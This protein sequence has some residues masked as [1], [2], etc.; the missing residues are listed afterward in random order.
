M[1]LFFLMDSNFMPAKF[2]ILPKLMWSHRSSIKIRRKKIIKTF[3][4]FNFIISRYCNLAK[5]IKFLYIFTLHV[6]GAKLLFIKK[7]FVYLYGCK[8]TS[9][10]FNTNQYKFLT[11][12][13]TNFI[14]LLRSIELTNFF[15][16]L[17]LHSGT[18]NNPN[19]ESH[20]M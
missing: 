18:Q 9:F 20:G 13:K 7:I 16:P 1:I 4:K 15:V 14:L 3:K 12:R 2:E 11:R 19:R 5:K 10:L 17:C 6:L 8:W